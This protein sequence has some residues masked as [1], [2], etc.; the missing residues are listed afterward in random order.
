MIRDQLQPRVTLRNARQLAVASIRQKHDRQPGLLGLGGF[1]FLRFRLIVAL[2]LGEQARQVELRGQRL[3]LVDDGGAG[4]KPEGQPWW[5]MSCRFVALK[6]EMPSPALSVLDL[7]PVRADQTSAD[8]VA[9]SLDAFNGLIG[10]SEDLAR[11]IESPA[12]TAEEQVSAVNAILAKAG[13]TGIAANFIGPFLSVI[14]VMLMMRVVK[15]S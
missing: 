1:R 15:L 14:G 2:P 13:I 6:R 8:A 9:A 5:G 12:F 7:V 11:L 3:S 4:L 10:E